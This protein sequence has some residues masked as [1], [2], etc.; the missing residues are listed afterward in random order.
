MLS[1]YLFLYRFQVTLFFR[2]QLR[3]NFPQHTTPQPLHTRNGLSVKTTTP[4]QQTSKTTPHKTH[5]TTTQTSHPIHHQH[6]YKTP[7][8]TFTKISQHHRSHK[9][10]PP[11]IITGPLHTPPHTT[12]LTSL[13]HILNQILTVNI[14]PFP[15]QPHQ[16]QTSDKTTQPTTTQHKIKITH[17]SRNLLVL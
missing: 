4:H 12:H 6:H 15:I 8:I 16:Q 11:R 7:F 5:T 10:I 13:P 14:F 9:R 17:N 2:K 3:H 1:P